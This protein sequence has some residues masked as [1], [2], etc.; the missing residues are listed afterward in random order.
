MLRPRWEDWARRRTTGNRVK[1]NIKRQQETE[2]TVEHS[3]KHQCSM[4]AQITLPKKPC[5]AASAR[6]RVTEASGLGR[7]DGGG[8]AAET[9]TCHH[10]AL[11]NK[12]R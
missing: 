7:N 10:S 3:S 2:L 1:L 6:A 5:G 12:K 8:C 4:P 11:A 9:T